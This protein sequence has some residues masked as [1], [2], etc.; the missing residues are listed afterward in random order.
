[1][2]V[3]GAEWEELEDRVFLVAVEGEVY[4]Q[5][6]GVTALALHKAEEE[7]VVRCLVAVILYPVGVEEGRR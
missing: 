2:L 1:L 6:L 4:Y 3:V 5:G 7:E